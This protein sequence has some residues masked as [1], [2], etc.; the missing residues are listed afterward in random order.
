MTT[1]ERELLKSQKKQQGRKK[2]LTILLII[3][4][5]IILV[6]VVLLLKA[7]NKPKA[8]LTLTNSIGEPT[9]PVKVIEFSNFGC[10][11]CKNFALNEQEKFLQTYVDTGKVYFTSHIMPW[12]ETDSTYQLSLASYCAAD[13]GKFF[14]FVHNVFNAFGESNYVSE[15]KLFQYAKDA[16][17][18][19]NELKTCLKDPLIANH[20]EDIQSLFQRYHLTGTPT[21]VVNGQTVYANELNE[22]IDAILA[23]KGE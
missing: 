10:V 12:N 23:E 6:A 19:I 7:F 20:A 18:N 16:D 3:A 9:A 13:Q 11:H 15:D 22:T 1:S 17:L 21:F 4:N 2:T 14:P 8:R 5:V